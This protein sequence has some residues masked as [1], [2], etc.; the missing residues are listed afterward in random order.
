MLF[1]FITVSYVLVCFF[2]IGVV[3]LQ[4]GRGGGLGSSFGGGAGGAGQTV[5]GGAGAGNILT[6]LTSISA[7]LFILLSVAMAYLSS[8][9]DEALDTVAE[10]QA[11]V[12]AAGADA[13]ADGDVGAEGEPAAEDEGAGTSGDIGL[14]MDLGGEVPGDGFAEPPPEAPADEAAPVQEPAL[15]IDPDAPGAG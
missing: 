15:D 14:Q 6:K 10:E 9:G 4:S 12:A 13:G 7:T 5:F 3:L 1:T 2:L 8:G 11:A